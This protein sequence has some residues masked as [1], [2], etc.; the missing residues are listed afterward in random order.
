MRDDKIKIGAITIG[1]S[2]RVDI[3][4]DIKGIL[5]Q[6]FEIIEM[7]ALD[8]YD[9]EYV[10]KSFYPKDGDTMLV[11]RM[12]D[13]TQVK[14]AEE[15][16]LK[17]IQE[18]IT[19]LEGRG[20]R[21]ILMLCTGKFPEFKH[22]VMLIRPQQILHLIAHQLSDSR[23]IG[24]FVPDESQADEVKKWWKMNGVE[25]EPVFASPYKEIENISRAASYF[26][27]KDVA[28]IFMDCMGYSVKMKKIVREISG[29][30]VLL[31]R[32]LTARI[33]KEL[34]E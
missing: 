16:I 2:P 24:V 8:P 21:A 7:G 3:T 15:K 6:E 34:F 17:I 20:C 26:K 1:Q 22:N 11:S 18:C 32:T 29:K 33:V 14:I 28:L 30:P 25:V 10:S 23:E 12:R 27:D 13:G 5:G 31:A 9:F 19:D 4:E